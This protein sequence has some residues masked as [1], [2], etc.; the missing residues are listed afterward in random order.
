MKVML[1]LAHPMVLPQEDGNNYTDLNNPKTNR[2]YSLKII[3]KVPKANILGQPAYEWSQNWWDKVAIIRN[4]TTQFFS[5]YQ[6]VPVGKHNAIRQQAVFSHQTF[7]VE[8]GFAQKFIL[9]YLLEQIGGVCTDKSQYGPGKKLWQR[10]VQQAY[11]KG[12][13]VYRTD[14]QNLVRLDSLHEF[15]AAEHS[16]WGNRRTV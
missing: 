16:I 1:A 11:L 13:F 4:G 7:P 6:V 9:E 14:E 10:V 3:A 2:D 15:K 8:K 5:S 12:L